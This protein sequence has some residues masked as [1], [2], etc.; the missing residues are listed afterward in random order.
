VNLQT[1]GGPPGLAALLAGEVA[2]RLRAALAARPL[3]SLVLSG[4]RTP[5]PFFEALAR[6]PLEWAR[7]G[8]TL[9]DERWVD[10]RSADSNER[11]VREH[12]LAGPARA[13]NFVSLRTGAHDP[14]AALAERR[15]ALATLAHPFDV[16]VL[17]MGDDGHTASLFPGAEGIESALDP[18]ASPGLIALTPPAAPHRRISMNLAMLLDS[19]WIAVHVLGE[20]KRALL[21]QAERASAPR[22]HPIAAVLRQHKVPVDVYWAP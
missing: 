18:A 8:V 22:E 11:L 19:R 5:L 7:V 4:G 3:A 21:E 15:A 10:A 17:G 6:E 20:S 9:A 13:A 12:L 16:V 1:A 14:T 2:R